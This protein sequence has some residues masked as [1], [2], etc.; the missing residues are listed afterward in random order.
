MPTK[1]SI[2]LFSEI[3]KRKKEKMQSFSPTATM[4]QIFRMWRILLATAWD[5]LNSRKKAGF[6]RGSV[7]Y[8]GDIKIFISAEKSFTSRF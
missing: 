5:Y 3:H 4:N 7:F 6:F 2:D 1:V 8:G